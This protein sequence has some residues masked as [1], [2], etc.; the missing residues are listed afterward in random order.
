MW[1]GV[2]VTGE[3]SNFSAPASGHWYF[4][5]KDAEAQIRCAMFRNRNLLVRWKVA[6]GKQV[7]ITGNVS[8]YEG[9]GE[10]QL[11][12]D[13]M[14][15]SGQ[16]SL[17]RRFEELKKKLQ[18]EGL[19]ESSRKKK[20]P[21]WPFPYW[22][23]YFADRSGHPRYFAGAAEADAAAGRYA[24][25][26]RGAGRQGSGR[27]H[28]GAEAGRGVEPAPAAPHRSLDCR[29]W[30]RFAGGISGPSTKRRLPVR[31]LPAPSRSSAPWGMRLTLPLPT[32][33]P[34]CAPP[35]PSAAAEMAS[36]D[37]YALFQQLDAQE[38]QLQLR[39]HR[40]LASCQRELALLQKGLRHPAE[41][42]TQQ[43]NR[44]AELRERLLGGMQRRLQFAEQKMQ[45]QAA[46]LH[47]VSPLATLQRGYAIV[48]S[49][50][51]HV[52]SNSRDTEPGATV[53]ARLGQGRLTCTVTGT[54][55][56]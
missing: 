48:T 36:P 47:T 26:L 7:T 5:L 12:A 18:A 6:N 42:L 22:R 10:F 14:E 40:T 29:A 9:R 37:Q 19:F 32:L 33:W 4:T 24:D 31:F 43:S 53:T 28:P 3:I 54:C 1:A 46:I 45:K 2:A 23:D 35:H 17:Q 11:V 41:R 44:V 13:A 55:E 30:W 50:A 27:D 39:I 56:E 8:L 15:E 25:S 49:E 34:M 51:N 38:K 16:G 52:I 21:A 20:L